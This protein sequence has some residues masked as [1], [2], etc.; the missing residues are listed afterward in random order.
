M[1]SIYFFAVPLFAAGL[2]ASC[3]DD[4]EVIV[5]SKPELETTTDTIRI[6]YGKT[7][8]LS[9]L[10]SIKDAG[11]AT[12][13]YEIESQPSYAV[14]DSALTTLDVYS[15]SGTTLTSKAVRVPDV[16]N[17]TNK[18]HVNEGKLKVSLTGGPEGTE[19]SVSATII[20]T[21]KP[22]LVPVIKLIPSPSYQ[23]GPEGELN[24]L[25]V[26]TKKRA[27]SFFTTQFEISP[28]DFDESDIAIVAKAGST[29]IFAPNPNDEDGYGTW[30]AGALDSPVGTEDYIVAYHRLTTTATQALAKPATATDVARL[31]IDVIYVA[32]DIIVGIELNTAAIGIKSGASFWR[33]NANGR[34]VLPGFVLLLLNDDTTRAW[35][36]STDSDITLMGGNF[37]EYLEGRTN[38]NS[39]HP[40]WWSHVALKLSGPL[41][42]VGTPLKFDITVKEHF[43]EEGWT[44]TVETT[45]LEANPE[46]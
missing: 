5:P 8:D 41:P 21:N 44:V 3:D 22:A 30:H 37:D 20:Q 28:I 40:G 10:F 32:A 1:K 15:V 25:E 38:Q 6:E 39:D 36:S 13:S 45:R 31:Y 11:N 27:A 18:R 2:L 43:L 9:T 19:Q 17:K 24:L 7:L 29:Y 35:N 42:E 26:K 46:S 33:N 16:V 14:N 4:S 34:Q 12:L 23:A